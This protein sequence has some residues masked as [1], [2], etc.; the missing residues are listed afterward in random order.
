VLA[1]HFRRGVFQVP[2]FVSACN[3]RVYVQLDDGLYRCERRVDGR[4]PVRM[5][6][7]QRRYFRVTEV[8]R[9]IKCEMCQ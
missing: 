4:S 8:A 5:K 7:G 2:V 6:S 1:D 3:N 9:E